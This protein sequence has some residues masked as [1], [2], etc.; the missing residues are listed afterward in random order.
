M[1]IFYNTVLL[2][3]LMSMTATKAVAYI[4]KIGNI[5]YVLDA[6]NMTAE[7]SGSNDGTDYAGDIDIPDRVIYKG[8]PYTVTSIGPAAF[9]YSGIESVSIPETV[10]RIEEQAFAFCSKLITVIIP[11]SVTYIGFYAFE[12]SGIVSV[13][14]GDGVTHIDNKA[15]SSCRSLSTVSIGKSVE[16]IGK[17]AFEECGTITKLTCKA[18]TPPSCGSEAF[19]DIDKE[20]CIVSVPKGCYY[21]YSHAEQWWDFKHINDDYTAIHSSY[22]DNQN[23]ID[24][25]Y[26]INGLRIP[27]LQKGLNI[28]R[29]NNGT[30]RKVVMKW[31]TGS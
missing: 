19:V 10:T 5:Y 14:I 2:V 30:T 4:E 28:I 16:K 18:T 22:V 26:S 11:N 13:T 3:M 6:S 20:K 29:M 23:G 15:F 1:K 31:S 17:R 9:F 8:Q 27:S 7:V 24:I 21:A 12:C 25:I